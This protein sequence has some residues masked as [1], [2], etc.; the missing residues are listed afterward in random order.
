VCEDGFLMLQS[1]VERSLKYNIFIE[2]SFK[3]KSKFIEKFEHNIDIVGKPL[4]G[5]I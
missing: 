5:K 4:M 2:I 1:I 3:S